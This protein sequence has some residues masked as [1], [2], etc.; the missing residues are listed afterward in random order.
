MSTEEADLAWTKHL[1][2]LTPSTELTR[3]ASRLW[4]ILRDTLGPYLPVPQFGRVE[5]KTFQFVWDRG[6][7]H[8]DIELRSVDRYEWFYLNR[9]TGFSDGGEDFMVDAP[10]PSSLV[11]RLKFV[12]TGLEID[13]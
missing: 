12:L 10:L 4:V 11:T 9:R 3:A 2:E 13:P 8:V 5:D 6:I 1:K 7:H